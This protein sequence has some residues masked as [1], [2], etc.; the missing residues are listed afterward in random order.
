MTLNSDR[1]PDVGCQYHWENDL[2]HTTSLWIVITNDRIPKQKDDNNKWNRGTLVSRYNSIYMK[3][4]CNNNHKVPYYKHLRTS[5]L[6][7]IPNTVERVLSV[8]CAEGTTEAEL[9]KQGVKVVGIEIDHSSVVAARGKGL[10]V[11]EGNV[12]EVDISKA[13]ER[14]D[15]LIYADILEHLYNPLSVLKRHVALL[16]PDGLVIISVPNFRHYSVFWKLFVLGQIKYEDAGILDFTHLR[17]TT[18]KMVLEWFKW[19]GLEPL[20]CDKVIFR[21]REKLISACFLGLA[22]DFLARQILIVGRKL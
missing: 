10:T 19:A 15:C 14:F 20:L 21:R 6:E 22:R 5:I 12:E 16:N 7:H 17:I 13:G 1:M 18:R 8:G 4:S 3:K 9:V 11:H 2:A